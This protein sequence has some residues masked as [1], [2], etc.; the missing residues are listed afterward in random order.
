MV[1]GI[2]EGWI[3][4]QLQAQA[5]ASSKAGDDNRAMKWNSTLAIILEEQGQYDQAIVLL[6]A[7]LEYRLRVLPE[8]HPDIGVT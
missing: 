4:E 5:A 2:M 7:V 1:F 3:K 8:N 6:E